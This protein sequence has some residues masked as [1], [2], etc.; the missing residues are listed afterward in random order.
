MYSLGILVCGCMELF[1]IVCSSV[2]WGWLRLSM[3]WLW[4]WTSI[5]EGSIISGDW[6][7][8]PI[9]NID[10]HCLSFVRHH[11]RT[12]F[13]RDTHRR[14]LFQYLHEREILM[15]HHTSLRGPQVQ[16]PAVL[17]SD[18]LVPHQLDT[19]TNASAFG[20]VG[21]GTTLPG[22]VLEK[23]LETL[24]RPLREGKAVVI[25]LAAFRKV[26]VLM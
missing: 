5:L 13:H 8:D 22:M 19:A 18:R 24:L 15:K 23:C 17:E 9:I 3:L 11:R 14:F 20:P 25:V 26:E 21:S 1:G 10:H 2:V 12:S 6:C 7:Q 4:R 16:K